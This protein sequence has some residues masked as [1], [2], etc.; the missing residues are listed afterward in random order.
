MFNTIESYTSEGTK[1]AQARREN[2][3]SKAQSHKEYYSRMY[4]LESDADK[5]QADKAFH[6]AYK[7]YNTA[8]PRL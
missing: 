3:E 2:D 4:S 1:C 5:K 8:H 7:A 6:N